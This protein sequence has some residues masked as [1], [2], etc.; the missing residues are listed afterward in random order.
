MQSR[1]KQYLILTGLLLAF[2]SCAQQRPVPPAVGR[3]R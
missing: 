1:I 3:P 2:G